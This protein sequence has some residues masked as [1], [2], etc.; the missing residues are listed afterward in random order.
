MDI[1]WYNYDL[2]NARESVKCIKQL[3]KICRDSL[4]YDEW[5]RRC[6]YADAKICPIC[7]DDYYE[8]NSKCETH[9]HPKTLFDIVEN[10]LDNHLE[11]N[12][13]DEQTGFNVVTEIM[14]K[15]MLGQVQYINIC[16]HCHKKYHNGHPD[17]V[18][19]LGLIFLE[20]EKIE[21]KKEIK[22]D[23][24]SDIIIDTKEKPYVSPEVST[25][26]VDKISEIIKNVDIQNKT[27]VAEM[28]NNDI[29]PI[30]NETPGVEPQILNIETSDAFVS[31]DIDKL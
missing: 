5:Q 12:D 28:P 29:K 11:K 13:L 4:E 10:I 8:N 9:H 7:N 23:V 27:F 19:K 26:M 2:S 30:L 3:E 14:D 21:R 17:V 18:T 6:K 22:E 1:L 20:R 16:Q 31:I 25:V 15:H 24:E